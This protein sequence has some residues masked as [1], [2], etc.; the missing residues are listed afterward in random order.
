MSPREVEANSFRLLLE[1]PD[2]CEGQAVLK[3]EFNL[4][5]G[6]R[7]RVALSGRGWEPLGEDRRVAR[8]AELLVV[9]GH[10]DWLFCQFAEV[11]RN[12]ENRGGARSEIGFKDVPITCD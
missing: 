9:L 12:E 8:R 10:Y 5:L 7:Y 2:A 3:G 1:L 6:V 11:S 4:G